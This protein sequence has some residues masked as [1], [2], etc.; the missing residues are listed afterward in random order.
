MSPL[1]ELDFDFDKELLKTEALILDGYTPFVDP[2]GGAVY[3][4]W[5]IKHAT[6][7][8]A[9]KITDYIRQLFDLKDCRPRFYIQKPGFKLG[10]HKDRGTLC[11]FNFLLSDNLDAINFRNGD[12][13]YQTCLLDVQEEHAVLNVTSDRILFKISIFDKTF[14]EIDSALPYKLQCR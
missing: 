1:T 12:R 8:Y 9:L 5:L 3:N 13:Y 11:S 7:D 6:S 10:F 2:L 4:D 14:G